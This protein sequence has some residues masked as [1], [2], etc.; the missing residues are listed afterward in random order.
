[1]GQSLAVMSAANPGGFSIA[2]ALVL[3]V[4]GFIFL[5]YGLARS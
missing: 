3:S 1:L 4:V 5:A 2:A